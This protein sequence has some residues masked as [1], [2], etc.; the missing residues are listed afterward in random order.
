MTGVRSARERERVEKA[1][2]VEKKWR[3]SREGTGKK[4]KAGNS[5]SLGELAS[6]VGPDLK[7]WMRP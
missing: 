4:K 6:S 2:D 3:N 1:A 5:P 7:K